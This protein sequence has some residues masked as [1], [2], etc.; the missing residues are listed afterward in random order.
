MKR[1]F[2]TAW[3]WLF[4]WPAFAGVTCTLPFT[5]TNG[6]IA[7]ATQVMANYNALVN[8]FA[9]NTAESGANSSITSISGLTT[10]LTTV[11]GGTPIYLGGTSGGSANAQTITPTTPSGFTLAQKSTIIFVAGFTNTGATTLTVGATAATNFFRQTPTGPQAMTGGEIVA[12]QLVVATYDGTQYEMISSG[13]QFGGFGPLTNLAASA[14]TDL[15]SVPSHDVNVTGTTTITSFGSSCN[16][17]F[18]IYKIK[19]AAALTLTYNATSLILPTTANITTAANDTATALCLG[20]GNWQVLS[21]ATA[22]GAP[23]SSTVNVQSF[24]A[25]GT[26]NRPAGSSFS[27]VILCGAGGGGGGGGREANLTATAGGGGGGGGYC[28]DVTYKF[29]DIG[30]SQTVTLGTAGTSGTGSTSNGSA[31]TAGGVGGSSTFGALL[32]AFGGGGGFGGLTTGSVG[33]GAAGAGIFAAGP[34]GT[35]MAASSEFNI[36]GCGGIS[37]AVGQQTCPVG[38]GG[39]GTASVS[40]LAG[41]IGGAS[42]SSAPGGG[43]GGGTTATP[44]GGAGGNGGKSI[45]CTTVPAGGAAGTNPGGSTAPDFNYHPGCGGGGGGGAAVTTTA[46]GAGGA[47]TNG[48]GGGGGG[49][50]DNANGGNGGAGGGGFAAVFSW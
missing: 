37:G 42:T 15:G 13:P 43:G 4:C 26:W 7:D 19:F 16:T 5:L 48:G 32:T 17:T 11:E 41:G 23:L 49:S 29:A 25:N 12:T 9:N 14:T 47:G 45:G 8:C 18:P 34:S 2:L 31:G 44:A 24:T 33:G 30:A 46:G 22:T 20:A 6:T 39:G 36:S 28:Q 3:F 10:P 38:G 1:L 21:Y 35:T 50:G 40:T 27:R